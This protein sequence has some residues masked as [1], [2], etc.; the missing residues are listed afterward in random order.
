MSISDL[1]EISHYCEVHPNRETELRCN[2]CD[3]YMCAECAVST[4][5]GYRCR[6]CVR[7]TEDRFFTSTTTDYLIVGAVS[8]ILPALGFFALLFSG[9]GFWFISLFAGLFI[10]GVVGTLGLRFTQKRRGRY[11]AQVA[12]GACIVGIVAIGIF[13]NVIGLT[14]LVYLAAATSTVYGRYQMKI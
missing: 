13:F 6:E 12:A 8:L 11:T 10:G 1:E 9:I 7:Q 4:P 5:V 3:R 14:F 2:K